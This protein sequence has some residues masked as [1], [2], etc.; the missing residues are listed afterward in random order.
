MQSIII[1]YPVFSIDILNKAPLS[2]LWTLQDD[3]NAFD[4]ARKRGYQ[5]ILD[6]IE[7]KETKVTFFC[8][9]ELMIM[10]HI[11]YL[12]HKTDFIEW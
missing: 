10:E 3:Y 4:L 11:Y 8:M 1:K 6:L 5:D 9:Y 7:R 2:F 12:E